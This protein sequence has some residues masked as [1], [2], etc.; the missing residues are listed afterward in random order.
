M[1]HDHRCHDM[2]PHI[3]GFENGRNGGHSRCEQN[4]TSTFIEFSSEKFDLIVGWILVATVFVSTN[5][6][7]VV[8]PG[9]GCRGMN[10]GR[11]GTRHTV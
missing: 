7:I 10:G 2:L 5:Q 6:F 11:D 4:C 1:V 9:K 3:D 8:I